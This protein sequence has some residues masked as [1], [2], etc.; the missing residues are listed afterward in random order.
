MNKVIYILAHIVAL[1]F[2][3]RDFVREMSRSHFVV[4]TIF[5]F[6][7]MKLGVSRPRFVISYDEADN[8]TAGYHF[9]M[10]I[11][12]LNTATGD[13]FAWRKRIRHELRHVWQ[14][15]NH[16][17]AV[18][19]YASLPSYIS[20]VDGYTY[21]P[22]EV[23][24]RMYGEGVRRDDILDEIGMTENYVEIMRELCKKEGVP[25]RTP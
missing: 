15:E 1:F 13:I 10:N 11:V 22:L 7:A 12:W 20:T 2:W 3:A 23:D 19:F 8:K 21:C 6:E 17:E 24:A 25:E 16:K 9:N 14:M 4:K 5:V 18:R